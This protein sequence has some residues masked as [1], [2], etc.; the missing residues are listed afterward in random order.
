M[1]ILPAELNQVLA[2][3]WESDDCDRTVIQQEGV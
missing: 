2:Q 1:M 3:S